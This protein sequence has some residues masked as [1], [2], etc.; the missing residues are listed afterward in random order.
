MNATW[1]VFSKK[2]TPEQYDGVV[3]ILTIYGYGLSGNEIERQVVK[4]GK[5]VVLPS[6]AHSELLKEGCVLSIEERPA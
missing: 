1:I 5:P 6:D 3:K 2:A 4:G